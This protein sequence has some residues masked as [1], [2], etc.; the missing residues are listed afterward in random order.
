LCFVF[1]NWHR[2]TTTYN[3]TQYVV[4]YEVQIFF[5]GTFLFQEVDGGDNTTT[6]TTNSWLRTTRLGT[7]NA[8]VTNLQY[9]FEFEIFYRALLGGHFHDGVLG[10]CV[11][12]Q[13]G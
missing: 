12:D 5:V 2:E 8:A 13:T 1:T 9:V 6:S 11:Q 3:V 7:A 10:L 4:E